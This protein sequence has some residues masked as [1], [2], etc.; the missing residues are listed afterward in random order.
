ML[1]E[2][3]RR[4]RDYMNLTQKTNISFPTKKTFVVNTNSNLINKAFSLRLKHND[5]AKDLVKQ[6]YNLSQLSQKELDPTQIL[7]FVSHSNKVLEELSN[8]SS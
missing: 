2:E 4:L 8:L 5:L 3:E 1:K 6:I 7:E